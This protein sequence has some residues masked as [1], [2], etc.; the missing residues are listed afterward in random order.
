MAHTARILGVA[1]TADEQPVAIVRHVLI[2]SWRRLLLIGLLFFLPIFF[3]YP[4]W[5]WPGYGPTIFFILVGISLLLAGR[6]YLQWRGSCLMVTNHRL[7]MTERQGVFHR[8]VVEAPFDRLADV[9]ATQRGMAASLFGYGTIRYR[10]QPGERR[11]AW[12]GVRHPE[13]VVEKILAA[14]RSPLETTT[15]PVITTAEQL[16][17]L[18]RQMRSELGTEQFSAIVKPLLGDD[19][20]QLSP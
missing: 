11:L 20:H 8:S 1:L 14:A 7:I 5:R 6:F 13:L 17:T 19:D 18:L 3:L 4:L 15:A 12:R 10:I 9:S 2:T 16:Q